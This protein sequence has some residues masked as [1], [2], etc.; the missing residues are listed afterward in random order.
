[1]VT[2]PL[3]VNVADPI[4]KHRDRILAAIDVGTNSVHMVLVNIQPSL[5][6][7]T[8][9]GREKSTVRLGDRDKTTGNLT[10]AA[11][12]RAIAALKRCIDIAKAAQAEQII[13]VAT[14]AMR[15]APNGQEFLQQIE[16]ELGLW[17]NLISGTEEA[18]RIYLGVLSGMSFGGQPHVLIDIGGGST[19]LILGDGDEPRSLSSTKVGAVRLNAQYVTTDPISNSEFTGLRSYIR[20]MLERPIEDIL[21]NRRPGEK[22]QMIATSGTA[23]T[24]AELNA[25]DK[26]GSV[27]SPLNGYQLSLKDIRE[28]VNR[29]RKANLAQRL[30]IPGMSERRAEILLAGSLI[31][32][33]AMEMLGIECLTICER[34]LREGVVVDWMLSRGMIE[35]RLRYHSSVRQRSVIKTAQKYRVNLEH[36]QRIADF[37]TSLFDQTV[38]VFYDWDGTDRDLLWASAILHNAGHHVSHSSHHKHSYYLVRH[39]DLLGYTEI[40]IETIANLARYHRKSGPKKKHENYRSLTSKRYRKFVDQMHPLLRLA[41]ALDRRQ[42]GAIKSMRCEYKP[43]TRELYLYLQPNQADDPCDLELWSLNIKKESFETTYGVKLIP[44]LG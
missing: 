23:E 15:E 20:G 31:L 34:S 35:D 9:V 1:M 40:E 36:S 18:R 30:A 5:P 3:P 44:V 26:T 11:M 24:L 19:E 8:I 27:P 43:A 7:F 25:R 22:L 16:T 6:A 41:V 38:G 21:V 4:D 37:A 29:L 17:V 10:P 33:E 32:Q 14:S 13:A 12:E 28:W 39:A 42:I 2:A